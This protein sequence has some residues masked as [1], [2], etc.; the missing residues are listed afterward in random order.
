[1]TDLK[2]DIRIEIDAFKE[3]H[4]SKI[5]ESTREL[6]DAYMS[7][8][9]KVGCLTT[10]DH[11]LEVESIV[12]NL[13]NLSNLHG[14]ILKI[15][16]TRKLT[17]TTYKQ[18]SLNAGIPDKANE[19][20]SP[21]FNEFERIISYLGQT[22]QEI[23]KVAKR[24]L[25]EINA[26]P[27]GEAENR[28]LNAKRFERK[29]IELIQWTFIDEMERIELSS[30][31]DGSLKRDAG[32]EVV[33][34]F[35]TKKYCGFE[36]TSLIVECKN[37]KKPSYK[38][39]MQL[40]TYTLPWTDSEISKNPLCLLVSR[41]NPKDDSVTWRIRKSIFNKP[42]GSETRLILFLDT[43]D[44]Q[45]MIGYRENGHPANIFK[46]KIQEFKQ[47]AIKNF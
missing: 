29:V 39:L 40:F 24:I 19:Y 35:D 30:I 27:H 12:Q 15:K 13:K 45:K 36:F 2:E 23:S 42:M 31:E 44:L 8:F 9:E 10:A 33:E 34:G 18:Y 26:C 41:E 3:T 37:Y 16:N 21:L 28:S 43:D 4:S 22:G 38:D 6:K 17:E 14:Q 1:M 7:V 11:F 5:D 32:F 25:K 20:F 46:E 47:D